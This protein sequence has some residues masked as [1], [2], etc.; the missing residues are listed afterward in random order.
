MAGSR[1]VRMLC[2][3]RVKRGREAAFLELLGRHW[4]TLR[5]AGL[6][7][8]EPAQVLRCRDK[9]G[10][11]TFFVETFSWAGA[12]ASA[13]AHESPSVMA[14]W[15]PMEGLLARM[16]LAEVEPVPMGYRKVRGPTPTRP[17]RPRPRRRR[18]RRPSGGRG[19]G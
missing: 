12:G 4:P 7:T 18:R 19:S 15:G 5:R 14:V 1:P 13:A 16:D 11:G 6:A 8:A 10:G 17:A 9:W 2:T 3:Y